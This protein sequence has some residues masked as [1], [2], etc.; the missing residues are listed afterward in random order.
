MPDTT[1]ATGLE[2]LRSEIDHVNDALLA[3]LLNRTELCRRVGEYKRDHGIPMMQQGRLDALRT[4]VQ[5]FAEEHGID[6]IHLE[7]I[8]DLITTDACRLENEIIGA[9]GEQVPTMLENCARRID[10][11]AIAVK[12]VD[13][14]VTMFEQRYGFTVVERRKVEGEFSGMTMVT[15]QAGGVTFV[16]CEGDSPRSNVCQ[17]IERFGPGVQHVAI[18]VRDQPQVV[19]DLRERRADL[20]TGIVSSPGLDQT[21]TRRDANTG[22]QF[23]FV[24]RTENSGFNNVKELFTAMESESVY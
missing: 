2:R 10:H 5:E 18:E 7:E 14:A 3:L 12:D 17:Y 9:D 21:F 19:D 1:H 24:T 16:L 11:V 13:E 15:M 22:M 4:K 6:S 20:L 8:F 23:E